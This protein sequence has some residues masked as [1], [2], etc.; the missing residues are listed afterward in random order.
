MNLVFGWRKWLWIY[1]TAGVFGNMCSCIFLPDSVGVGS[2]GAL[3]GM[4]T[5]WLTWIM[6]RW[7]KIP[8]QCRMQ[9]NC[10]LV[11]VASSV[12]VTLGLSFAQFVDWAA[13]F[14]GALQGLIWGC[15][16]LSHELDNENTRMIVRLVGTAAFFATFAI[17][18]YY[19]AVVVKPSTANFALWAANDDW[20]HHGERIPS[21]TSKL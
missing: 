6:F 2:S 1:L 18:S 3:L 19:L 17:A 9:R 7:Q 8:E 5:A 11:M 12:A 15:I 16:L 13:H 10:Q 20:N 14:G 21:T 4:L